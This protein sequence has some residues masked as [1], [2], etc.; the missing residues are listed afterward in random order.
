VGPIGDLLVRIG[1]VRIGLVDQPPLFWV[2]QF[3]ATGSVFLAFSWKGA[4]IAAFFMMGG[5]APTFVLLRSLGLIR[6]YWAM[7]LPNMVYAVP[8]SSFLIASYFANVPFELEDAAKIDGAGE[9]GRQPGADLPAQRT[10]AAR[11]RQGGVAE[12]GRGTPPVRRSPSRR[13]TRSSGAKST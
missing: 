6:A 2:D 12:A 9:P 11:P 4:S 10:A 1:V 13:E 3:L 7:I 5:L 8:L